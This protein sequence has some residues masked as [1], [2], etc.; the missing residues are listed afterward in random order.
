MRSYPRQNYGMLRSKSG[1]P[2]PNSHFNDGCLMLV[3]KC[4][5]I[6]GVA[7]QLLLHYIGSSL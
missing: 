7:E 6:I 1:E 4:K 3:M 5:Q 2:I